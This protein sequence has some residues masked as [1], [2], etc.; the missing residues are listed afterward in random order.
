MSSLARRRRIL[1]QRRS[2]LMAHHDARDDGPNRRYWENNGRADIEPNRSI[3]TPTPTF[4]T[5]LAK[6][7]PVSEVASLCRNDAS[8]ATRGECPLN[9]ENFYQTIR[10]SPL[11]TD[12]FPFKHERCDW[13]VGYKRNSEERIMT[14]HINHDQISFYDESLKKQ[15]EGSCRTDGKA[16]HVR[17]VKYG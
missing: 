4:D 9:I 11:R 16:V 1:L 15:I 10:R 17:S 13:T 8:G 6:A 14:N 2:S 5:G 3:L 7:V 12:Q